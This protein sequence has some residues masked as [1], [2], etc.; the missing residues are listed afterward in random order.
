MPFGI[1]DRVGWD[2]LERSIRFAEDITRST[3]DGLEEVVERYPAVRRF[4]PTFLAAFTFRT[5]RSGDPLLGAIDALRAMSSVPTSFITPR[6]RKVVQPA[7]GT[8]D[9]RAYEIAV[10]VHLRER[11][12]SGGTWMDGSR[13]YRTLDD[14]QLPVPAFEVMRADGELR[15]AVPTDFPEWYDERR[16]LLARCM[17]EAERGTAAGE[18]VG[19][20]IE[21]GHLLISPI[22]RS[23]SNDAEALKARLYA[24]LPRV[25]ITDLLAEVAA[26][27]GFTDRFVHTRC[28]APASDLSALMSAILADATNLGLGR[29][30]ENSR[31]LT[32]PRL[33]W[34]AEW[35][36][37]DE[38]YLSALAAIVDCHTAHPLAAVWGPG[39]TSSSDGQ[40]F[41]ADGQGEVRADRNARYGTDPVCCSTPMSPTASRRSTARSSPP[42]Q[43]RP[44]TSLTACSTMRASW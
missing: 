24:M 4:A 12:G 25:R 44:R 16:T 26:W 6:W 5:A 23:P 29:M 18:L 40:F 17:T 41:R 21:R 2:Q 3:G 42:M 10:I 31:G 38:A 14:D 35:H 37:R 9:S 33:R 32:L 28:G 11:L 1:D 39:D 7:E 15:L 27:S 43:A 19:V 30:A 8:V 13:A 36:V 20:T 22:R 34:T